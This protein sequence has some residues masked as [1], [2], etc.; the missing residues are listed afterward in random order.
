MAM[1]E[2]VPGDTTEKL[3]L[4]D[5]YTYL[6]P[7]SIVRIHRSVAELPGLRDLK[8]AMQDNLVAVGVTLSEAES[9][10]LSHDTDL[11]AIRREA[12]EK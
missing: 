11:F 4:G 7:G 1:I 6:R 3:F 2:V 5:F 12:E 10:K 9:S 8:Q